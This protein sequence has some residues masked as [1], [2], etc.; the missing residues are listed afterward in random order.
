MLSSRSLSSRLAA[1]S[2]GASCV[3]FILL[4]CSRSRLPSSRI[5]WKAGR[6]ASPMWGLAFQDFRYFESGSLV[7]FIC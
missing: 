5:D 3:F 2:S 6:A 4:T 7:A 1:L